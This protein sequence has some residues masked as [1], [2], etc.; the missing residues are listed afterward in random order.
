MLPKYIK[1]RIPKQ[2][3]LL[4][5]YVSTD[6]LAQLRPVFFDII[7]VWY[8]SL[9]PHRKATVLHSHYAIQW[10]DG[11]E[12]L[13]LDLGEF[14]EAIDDSKC[15]QELIEVNPAIMIEVDT[16]GDIRYLVQWTV[17]ILLFY[18]E[19]NH[20]LKFLHGNLTCKNN[21]IK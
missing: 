7:Q 15:L 21:F 2:D 12:I 5:P 11:L 16:P 18:K 19:L 14:S 1:K 3:S 20:F 4:T 10:T 6:C 17:H 13:L 9:G 8:S